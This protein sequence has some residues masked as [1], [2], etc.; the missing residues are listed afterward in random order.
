MHFEEKWADGWLWRRAS[1]LGQWEKV[2]EKQMIARMRH[3]L[4][5]VLEATDCP[6]HR[7][8]DVA[9]LRGALLAARGAA[10]TALEPEPAPAPPTSNLKVASSAASAVI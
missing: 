7:K 3:A 10:F 8:G 1:P 5:L 4:E 9:W 6:E 2:P